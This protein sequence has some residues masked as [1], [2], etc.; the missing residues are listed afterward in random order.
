MDDPTGLETF[1]PLLGQLGIGG[2]VLWMFIKGVLVTGAERDHWY[3]AYQAEHAA[4]T[5]L[6]R[7]LAIQTERAATA[8]A[9]LHEIRG[10]PTTIKPRKPT[11]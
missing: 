3:E 5:E 8:V 1:V 4:R 2:A 6:E 7:S 11:S 10:H 9:T